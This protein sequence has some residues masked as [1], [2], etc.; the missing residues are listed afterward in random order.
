MWPL[1]LPLPSALGL[2]AT[3]PTPILC[4][5]PWISASLLLMHLP[6]PHAPLHLA[7]IYG[8]FKCQPGYHFLWEAA[9]LWAEKLP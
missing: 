6:Q 8:S 1:W 5:A 9:P 2:P 3:S 7:K 4:S